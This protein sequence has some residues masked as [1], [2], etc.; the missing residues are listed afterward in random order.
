MLLH[1]ENFLALT[2]NLYLKNTPLVDYMFALQGRWV[3]CITL[4]V[5]S[6]FTT[7]A[8][9]RIKYFFFAVCF[10]ECV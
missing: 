1:C 6:G 5:Q 9:S 3:R 7:R 10:T 4:A 8:C 2:K